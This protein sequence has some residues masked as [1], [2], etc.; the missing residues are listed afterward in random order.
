LKNIETEIKGNT[1]F[2]VVISDNQSTDHT[3]STVANFFG[4]LNVKYI[5]Q[6][7]NI[8]GLKNISSIINYADGT[9]C[10]L[11]GDDD[12]FRQGWLVL[13]KSLVQQHRP[14]V[15]ISNRFVCDASLNIK[16]SEQCGPDVQAP[17]LYDCSQ[18]NVLHDYLS[19]TESTSGFGF[20]SN[21]VVRKKSWIQSSHSN[22]VD[23]HSFPH[24]LKILDILNLQKGSVLR[25]P[26][27][28]VY[29]C[30]ENARLEEQ[31]SSNE[32]MTELDKLNIHFHGFLSAAN[33]LFVDS[34]K[35]RVAF[36]T[37]IKR[38]FSNDYKIY[39]ISLAVLVNKEAIAR[40]FIEQLE[41]ALDPALTTITF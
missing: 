8:G 23:S 41:R 25:V 37:P 31:H 5:R 11:I 2:Q 35:L 27:E 33:I 18:P 26:F 12:V 28:T 16:F 40:D 13:L 21:Q 36:L 34:P 1:D 9:Y 7:K 10:I 38:I 14:D 29:A 3:Y 17:T 20:I 22:I 24:M 4:T 19:Q 6:S 15:I 32:P 39:Y 30:A